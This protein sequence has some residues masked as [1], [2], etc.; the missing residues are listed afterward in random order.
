MHMYIHVNGYILLFKREIKFIQ[1]EGKT[2]TG[3]EHTVSMSLLHILPGAT[4]LTGIMLHFVCLFCLASGKKEQ[5]M[6]MMHSKLWNTGPNLVLMHVVQ[7]M[8]NIFATFN[9]NYCDWI[10]RCKYF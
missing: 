7:S 10:V 1:K 9:M 8:F 3:Y 2:T 6:V 5:D 4:H